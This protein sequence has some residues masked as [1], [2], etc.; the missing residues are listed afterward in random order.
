M[1]HSPF[2][3]AGLALAA[4]VAGL[5]GQAE[6]APLAP[7][8]KPADAAP[9]TVVDLAGLPAVAPFSDE[10]PIGDIERAHSDGDVPLAAPVQLSLPL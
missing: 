7:A 6:V 10:D 9:Q 3:P 1:T 5:A 4:V 2:K 8:A